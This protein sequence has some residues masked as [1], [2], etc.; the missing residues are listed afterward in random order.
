MAAKDKESSSKK[1]SKQS[2]EK[3]SKKK[4][5]ADDETKVENSVKEVVDDESAKKSKQDPLLADST[6]PSQMPQYYEFELQKQLEN[7][8]IALER[9]NEAH[10]NQR[11]I[12]D[13][14]GYDSDSISVLQQL[15][16]RI[17]SLENDRLSVINNMNLAKAMNSIPP[18][19][20]NSVAGGN[21]YLPANQYAPAVPLGATYPSTG[22]GRT[23]GTTATSS[24]APTSANLSS[25]ATFYSPE[26]EAKRHT[27]IRTE[28]KLLQQRQ[29]AVAAQQYAQQMAMEEQR[30]IEAA[31]FSQANLMRA[32]QAAQDATRVAQQY[33]IRGQAQ[34]TYA[35][36]VQ[37]GL[38]EIE[39]DIRKTRHEM[40]LAEYQAQLNSYN[41]RQALATQNA[42]LRSSMGNI[43]GSTYSS[44]AGRNLYTPLTRSGMNTWNNVG[45][46]F[47]AGRLY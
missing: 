39:N 18:P 36:N 5:P 29:A 31:R 4:A 28:S 44:I 15:V 37:T 17:I 14:Y 9:T 25:S 24:F 20:P 32:Q 46:G 41:Q 12:A 21:Y 11:R 16:S 10:R 42:R 23:L 27:L 7:I 19:M 2:E 33:I 26:V 13:T 40:A 30:A 43:A 6:F 45:R 8:E 34:R 22:F 1:P 47:E 38:F 3:T 35:H